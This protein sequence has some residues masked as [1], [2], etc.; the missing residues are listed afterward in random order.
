MISNRLVLWALAIW[1]SKQY[2]GLREKGEEWSMYREGR[3][4]EG[5]IQPTGPCDFRG[6]KLILNPPVL[7]IWGVTL[8]AGDFG[9]WG[10]YPAHWCQWLWDVTKIQLTGTMDFQQKCSQ[11]FDWKKNFFINPTNTI[12]FTATSESNCTQTFFSFGTRKKQYTLGITEHNYP[13]IFVQKCDFQSHR[14]R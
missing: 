2:C 4:V 12:I 7:V 3:D 14:N 10:W 9:E 6:K 13:A 1:I 11:L 5:G 8:S